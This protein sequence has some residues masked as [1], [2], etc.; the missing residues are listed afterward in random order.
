[1]V[2]KK[3]RVDEALLEP[4]TVEEAIPPVSTVHIAPVACD[5]ISA[6]AHEEQNELEETS[7]PE[8][9]SKHKVFLSHSGVEKPFVGKLCKLL[10]EHNHYPFFDQRSDSLPKGKKF[11]GLIIEAAKT[12]QVA[13]VV[14]SEDYL[15]SKWPMTELAEFVWAR[16]SG[17]KNLNLPPLFYKASASFLQSQCC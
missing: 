8:L 14:L 3:K 10:E 11:A 5:L 1:M 17:N 16:K 13:V 4:T 7:C 12:C 15:S 9:D 6:P 2:K